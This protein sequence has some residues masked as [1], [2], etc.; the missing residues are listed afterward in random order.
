MEW[1]GRAKCRKVIV[2]SM[3]DLSRKSGSEVV[4]LLSQGSPDA[5]GG[6]HSTPYSAKQ[7]HSGWLQSGLLRGAWWLIMEYK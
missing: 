6:T 1:V 3:G 5:Q 4:C 7:Q 2:W